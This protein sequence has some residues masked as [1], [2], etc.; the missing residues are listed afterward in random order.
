MSFFIELEGCEDSR[1]LYEVLTE[2]GNV[3]VTDMTKMVLI[4]GELHFF[5]IMKAVKCCKKHGEITHFCL[6]KS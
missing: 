4:Y 6:N 1:V 5:D 2:I 3:N